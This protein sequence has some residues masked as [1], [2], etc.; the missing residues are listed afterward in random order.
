M[1]FKSVTQE[2]KETMK[3]RWQRKDARRR[4]LVDQFAE[5]RLKRKAMSREMMRTPEQ[6]ED[7]K[8]KLRS[9]PRDSAETR[10][11]NRCV[12]TGRGRSVMGVFRRSR[13]VIREMAL[14]GRLPGVMKHS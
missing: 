3:N 4:V 1:Y 9:L 2:G 8:L 5:E 14:S 11:C 6:R 13:Y 10:R 12:E 7:A